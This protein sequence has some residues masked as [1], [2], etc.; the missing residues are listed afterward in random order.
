MDGPKILLVISD[1]TLRPAFSGL[2]KGLGCQ[3]FTTITAENAL[4]ALE[5]FQPAVILADMAIEDM[6]PS[7]FLRKIKDNPKFKETPLVSYTRLLTYKLNNP[8]LLPKNQSIPTSEESDR[9][10]EILRENIALVPG[11]IVLWVEEAMAKKN[12]QIPPLLTASA[13]ILG[14]CRA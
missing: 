14:S 13:Q 11:E 7:G 12:V 5:G 4:A 6:M 9:A 8:D 2:F 3:V 1:K 10:L